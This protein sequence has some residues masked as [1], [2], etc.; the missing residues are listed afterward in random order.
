MKLKLVF[1]FGFF[2]V[3]NIFSGSSAFAQK[4]NKISCSDLNFDILESQGVIPK[5]LWAEGIQAMFNEMG[6]APVSDLQGMWKG[7]CVYLNAPS[8]NDAVLVLKPV[9]G[10]CIGKDRRSCVGSEETTFGVA[11]IFPLF[12]KD[13]RTSDVSVIDSMQKSYDASS[14]EIWKGYTGI[15][16]YQTVYTDKLFDSVKDRIAKSEKLRL[17]ID[18]QHRQFN[19]SVVHV[20]GGSCMLIAE[21]SYADDERDASGFRK[22]SPSQYCVFDTLLS[23]KVD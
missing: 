12:Q 5:G 19:G 17:P 3:Q 4:P 7:R 23:G 14:S 22:R 11:Q 1:V 10:K 16:G 9:T 15:D 21:L 13:K 2:V 8:E 18:G 6:T 20:K